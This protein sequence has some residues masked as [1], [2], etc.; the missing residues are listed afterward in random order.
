MIESTSFVLFNLTHFIFHVNEVAIEKHFED[1][2][3]DQFDF[4]AYCIRKVTLRSYIQ[5]LRW[6]DA[7]WGHDVYVDAAEAIIDT[8][9]NLFDNPPK[10]ENE[11]NSEPDYSKMTP[12]ERKK[13][14]AQARKRKKKAEKKA[15]EEAK[16]AEEAGK[17]E[18]GTPP[19]KD[20]DPDGK[21][22]LKLDSLEQA[23][24]YTSTLV[25]NAP[26]R[27]STWLYQYDVA[28]RRNKYLLALQA[29][30]KAKQ[31]CSYKKSG[32]VFTRMV[33]FGSMD[34]K[35]YDNAC[36]Q[37][38]FEDQ[39]QALF[40]GKQLSEF[41]KC[42]VEEVKE[43]NSNLSDRVAV[44]KIMRRLQVGSVKDACELIMGRGLN[45]RGLTLASCAD[46]VKLLKELSESDDN[47]TMMANEWNAKV[48]NR[49]F[50]T[51]LF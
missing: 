43:S 12:A 17:D 34:I 29:L 26:T 27:L 33:D 39:K 13:A 49:F 32:E 28:F 36:V 25:K 19:P 3:E 18:D 1:F 10:L 6:E 48:K 37:K 40:D 11:M 47:L 23:K 8:Y 46:S 2:N 16:Q 35:P 9:L 45:I 21:E 4:H 14:K 24:K 41:V 5:V 22:L 15:E 7:L 30:N 42:A 44:A 38:V 51:S 20:N 31:I 50:L